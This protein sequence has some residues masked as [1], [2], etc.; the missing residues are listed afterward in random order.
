MNTKRVFARTLVGAAVASALAASAWAQQPP[1]KIGL[2]AGGGAF[3]VGSAVAGYGVWAVG[4]E[5]TAKYHG[6][7]PEAV[8]LDGGPTD[9]TEIVNFRLGQVAY[10]KRQNTFAGVA[11]G[12]GVVGA[13]A[14]TLGLVVKW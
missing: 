13:T 11:A 14:L 7:S 5:F 2:L 1:V 10:Q 3:L 9:P 6:D 8:P 4:E 12:A